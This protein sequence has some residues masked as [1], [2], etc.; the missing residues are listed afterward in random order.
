MDTK[1]AKSLPLLV[2]LSVLGSLSVPGPEL[3]VRKGYR[4]AGV[5]EPPSAH[6]SPWAFPAVLSCGLPQAFT[7]LLHMGPRDN[8]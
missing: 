7:D 5:T 6:R 8:G 2:N 4:V 3:S 1:A